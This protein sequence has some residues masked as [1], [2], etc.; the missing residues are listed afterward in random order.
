VYK[1]M[2]DSKPNSLPDFLLIGELAQ[3]TGS[4]PKTI[5]FYEREGLIVPARHGRFRIYSRRDKRRLQAILDMRRMGLPIAQIR[6]VLNKSAETDDPML[7]PHFA[8]LLSK[9]LQDLTAKQQEVER[10]I[11]ETANALRELQFKSAV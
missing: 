1:G 7:T 11:E 10:Q 9:H 5:R 3:K 4:S 6:L 2:E 8:N